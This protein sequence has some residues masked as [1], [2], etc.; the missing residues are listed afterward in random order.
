MKN[1]NWR[2]NHGQGNRYTTGNFTVRYRRK[3]STNTTA[4]S[5]YAATLFCP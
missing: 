3:N 4:E 5:G 1:N 2:I